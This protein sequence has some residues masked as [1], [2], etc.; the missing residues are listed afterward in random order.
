[1]SVIFAIIGIIGVIGCFFF[2]WYEGSWGAEYYFEVY[3]SP[4]A[5]E[6]LLNGVKWMSAIYIGIFVALKL[7]AR[8]VDPKENR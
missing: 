6:F 3:G 1:M 7:I 2:P 8:K 4:N 5:Y